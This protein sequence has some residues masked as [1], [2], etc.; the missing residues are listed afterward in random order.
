[1]YHSRRLNNKI[2][3]LHERVYDDKQS[4]SEQPLN[5]DKSVTIQHRNVQ[6]GGELGVPISVLRYS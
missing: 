6:V 3:E 4:T 2:N 5:I 1:M